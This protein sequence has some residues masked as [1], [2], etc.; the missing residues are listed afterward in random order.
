[1]KNRTVSRTLIAALVAVGLVGGGSAYAFR[2][3]GACG[4]QGMERMERMERNPG[5]FAEKRLEKLHTDLKLSS[6]QEGAWKTWS[7]PIRQQTAAMGDM[8]A[9]REQMMKLPAPDRMEK[10]L[11]RMKEHQK[12]ME[13]Q[14]AATRSFYGQLNA[15]Q[16]KT[17]DAFQPF[18]GPRG[19]RGGQGG[20]GGQPRGPAPQQNG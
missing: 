3:D 1:M 8:R 19:E 9:E 7:D 5:K 2:G 20:R 16:K 17:F 13:A 18:G 4:P 11:E 15:E 12:K 14:L 10:M 6:E